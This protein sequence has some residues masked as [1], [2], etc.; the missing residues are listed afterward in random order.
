MSEQRQEHTADALRYYRETERE[1]RAWARD[2]ARR[3]R[4]RTFRRGLTLERLA[5][6]LAE[7]GAR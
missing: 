6:W 7:G 1:A 5:R 3:R 4:Q 2:E